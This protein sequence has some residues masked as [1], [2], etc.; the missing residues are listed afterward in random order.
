PMESS[1]IKRYQGQTL[2]ELLIS[3]VMSAIL[4]IMI[5]NTWML[6]KKMVSMQ[7]ALV[8][9][10]V[11]ARTLDYIL[12]KAIRNH[13][14]FGC[15]RLSKT[16]LNTEP[17][18]GIA[19]QTIP[20][21]LRI[22]SRMLKRHVTD[23]DMLWLQASIQDFTQRRITPLLIKPGTKMIL[24]DCER[25]QVITMPN[26]DF[27]V[28][29]FNN[30]A[31][32]VSVL[33]STIYYVAKSKRS[34]ASGNAIYGLYST[35][36][37]GRTLELIEGVEKLVFTY[38]VLHLGMIKY[39]QAEDISDWHAVVSVRLAALLNSVEE[40]E[41]KM[42]KWWSFEWPLSTNNQGACYS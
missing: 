11:N 37:N 39:Q 36:F 41:P 4:T 15:Q 35:D 1:N 12:G 17:L 3:L 23:S 5:I 16:Q 34:N 40:H 7:Q 33:S 38:G 21:T 26:E 19:Y 29:G 9:M 24:S 18:Q 10:Q 28:D 27:T 22:K 31:F 25:A 14:V 2:I 13:G 30:A 32:T 42:R 20:E 6:I 8:R